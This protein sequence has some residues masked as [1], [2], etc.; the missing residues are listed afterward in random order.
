MAEGTGQ[1]NGLYK[2]DV[3]H[4]LHPI[5]HPKDHSQQGPRIMEKAE[6]IYVFDMQGEQYIDGLSGLWNVNIGHH[7]P[8]MAKTVQEQVEKLAFMP[9]FFGF[10]NIPAINLADKLATL[11]PRGLKKVHFTSGGSETNETNLK[12]ARYYHK[13]IGKPDKFKIISR[14]KA[15]HGISMGA[16]SATGIENYWKMFE[17]LAPGFF[18]IAPPYCYQCEL[19]LTYPSCKLAC[20]RQLEE[21]IEREGK[22]TV[23]AFIGEPVMGA[24]GVI[25]PPDDYWSLIQD[26]CRR[27]EVLLIIDE[28][29]TGFGRTGKWFCSDHYGLEPDLLSLAKGI[30]SGYIPLGA[31]MVKDDIHREMMEHIPQGMPFMHGFT[32]SGHPVCCSAAL[33]NLGIIEREGLVGNA[34]TTG[35]YLQ[36]RLKELSDLP[37]VGETRGKGLMAAI[38]LTSDKSKH[39]AFASPGVVGANV[40]RKAY[41]MGLICRAVGDVIAVAPPLIITKHQ[42]DD[43]VGI[44]REVLNDTV[45][46]LKQ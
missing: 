17:P 42:V 20:A 40:A 3:D 19:N 37:I 29:I 43:L 33:C 46:T 10:S 32:Y 24:A 15:Y 34:E 11:T 8:E 23:A 21:I 6:G 31:A 36:A 26:I 16:M 1:I 7:R 22:E 39:S 27:N 25:V 45:K 18:H 5:I 2:K 12:L 44:L 30:T 41:K 38:E 35:A 4:V 9:T 13:L 14:R 28:V